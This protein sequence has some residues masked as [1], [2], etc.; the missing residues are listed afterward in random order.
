MVS[1]ESSRT[2]NITHRKSVK[3]KVSQ[4]EADAKEKKVIG[5]DF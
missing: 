1:G 4:K 2:Q 3:Q 5:Y